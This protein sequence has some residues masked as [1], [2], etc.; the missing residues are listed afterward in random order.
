MITTTDNDD[1][2]N[3]DGDNDEVSDNTEYNTDV[4]DEDDADCGAAVIVLLN[5]RALTVYLFS[6]PYLLIVVDSR[7]YVVLMC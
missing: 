3:D 7:K 4:E 6:L 5:S 1:V 2:N